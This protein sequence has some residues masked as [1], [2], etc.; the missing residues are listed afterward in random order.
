MLALEAKFS[1]DPSQAWEPEDAPKS[2]ETEDAPK[3]WEPASRELPFSST[4]IGSH[5]PPIA[6][7]TASS[8]FYDRASIGDTRH[9][10]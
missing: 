10:S 9:T 8:T 1:E 4:G 7:S 5:P 3:I 6:P 2:W